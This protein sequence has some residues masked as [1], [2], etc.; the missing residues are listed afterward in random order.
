MA[1]PDKTT[2]SA[3]SVA[4]KKYKDTDQ[5]LQERL[6]T[7]LTRLADT[8]DLLK[9]WPVSQTA[10]DS[11]IHVQTTTKLIASIHKVV[12]GIKYVEEKVNRGNGSEQ[13]AQLIAKLRQAAVPLDL[14]DMMDY[15][16]G[17]NPDCFARGLLREALRQLGDLQRRKASLKMLAVTIQSGIN[18]RERE[19]QLEILKSLDEQEGRL[20]LQHQ[21]QQMSNTMTVDQDKNKK[22]KR[23]M[24]ATV[25]EPAL[26]IQR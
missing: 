17:L 21:D 8:S 23:N 22:R 12:Q 9:N 4:G 1:K 16:N 26:K 13:D 7:L 2:S 20:G 6:H 3:S 14:L 15:G 18:K 24:H 25:D 10:D 11:S 19:R 5:S